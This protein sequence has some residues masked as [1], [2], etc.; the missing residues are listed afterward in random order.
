MSLKLA[1]FES[2]GAVSY[3][4]FIVTIAIFCI[5]CERLIDRKSGNFYTTPV[6]SAPAGGD[7]VRIL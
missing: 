5:V 2:L 4:P 1:P 6:F 3:S 7:P